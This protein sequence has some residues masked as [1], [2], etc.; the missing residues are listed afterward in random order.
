VSG[1]TAARTFEF[2]VS[3]PTRVKTMK[4]HELARKI[5]QLRPSS[6]PREVARACLMLAN[7]IDTLDDLANEDRLS[8]A[9]KEVGLRLQFAT[10]QHAAVTQELEELAAS[11]PEKFSADQ[12]W[13]L[14]RAIKVQ[15]Q[16]LQL[17]LGDE[18][19]LDV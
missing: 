15:S 5:D 16:V 3:L 9:W 17:Y 1:W 8:E 6:D 4:I 14:V 2:L 7:S 11:D 18:S 19:M 13:I 12:I 10:D